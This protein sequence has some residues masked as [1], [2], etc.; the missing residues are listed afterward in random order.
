MKIVTMYGDFKDASGEVHKELKVQ[1]GKG[2]FDDS[3]PEE[4]TVFVID[5]QG[6][7]KIYTAT[8]NDTVYA[9]LI[10]AKASYRSMELA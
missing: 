10:Q 6:A 1:H 5:D 8:H 4:V 3:N 7:E 9:S 2:F